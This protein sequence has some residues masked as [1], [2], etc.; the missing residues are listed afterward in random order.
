MTYAESLTTWFVF[1]GISINAIIGDPIE[2]VLMHKVNSRGELG[3]AICRQN[4]MAGV[5]TG[6]QQ[7]LISSDR[8]TEPC[9]SQ[10]HGAL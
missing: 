7:L 6:D 8:C 2:A 1:G 5:H 10:L 4:D 3:W 9:E